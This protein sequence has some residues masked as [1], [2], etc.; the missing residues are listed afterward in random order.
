MKRKPDARNI[1]VN[2]EVLD[3]AYILSIVVNGKRYKVTDT[4]TML[5]AHLNGYKGWN[6]VYAMQGPNALSRLIG[7]I[8]DAQ[9]SAPLSPGRRDD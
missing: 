9:K 4:P 1:I 2:C 5:K 7:R 6:A 3:R 8:K